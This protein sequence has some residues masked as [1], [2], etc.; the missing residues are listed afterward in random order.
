MPG[1][2]VAPR[3]SSRLW[4]P[5]GVLLI[6]TCAAVAIWF[7][8]SELEG[9]SRM[10]GTVLVAAVTVL[11][12]AFWLLFLARF[13]RWLRLGAIA[14]FVAA[15][16]AFGLSVREV[17]FLGDMLPTF[18]F[19]WEKDHDTLLEEERA[20]Q[21][22]TAPSATAQD[23]SETNNSSFD[24]FGAGRDGIVSNSK[25]DP[26]W[27]SH[28]PKQLWHQLV[29]GGYAGFALRD[30]WAVTIEQRRDDEAVVRYD[31]ATGRETWAHK[32]RAHF[33]EPLGGP[34]P[35]ATP[36]IVD[37]A[38]N[39]KND[40]ADKK[41]YA[42]G[43]TGILK[44]LDLDSGNEVW[45]A[46]IL[47]DNTN[48]VWGMAASPLVVANADAEHSHWVIVAPGA[49]SS[50]AKGR[51]VIIYDAKSGKEIRAFG[52]HR[53]GYSSPVIKKLAG[54][55]QLLVFDGDGLTSYDPYAGTE[56]WHHPWVTLPPQFINV[57]QPIVLDGD[58]VFLSSGYSVGCAM[59]Q[60]KKDA[61]PEVLWH[62]AFMR[63]K[64]TSPVHHDGYLYGLD[65]GILTCLDAKTGERK[66]KGG[67]YGHG[68][69]LL[70]DKHLLILSETG[71]LVL[72]E[73]TPEKHNQ[74][75]KL[76]ALTGKTWNPPALSAC[77]VFIR[78]HNE[79]AAYALPGRVTQDAE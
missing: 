49:Q 61:A 58:R 38:G 15:G 6:A 41:V 37:L 59:L 25:L 67:R 55:D 68:Q 75:A 74:M 36:I 9:A 53:G 21:A 35:R 63:C 4:F 78:N 65:D 47:K 39:P 14:V 10:A 72:V 70:A 20:K 28:P 17:H 32:Y 43:A 73:S 8:P 62:N 46:D 16:V 24:F 51:A 22:A 13:S 18:S 5:T 54:I 33:Q 12:L 23:R 60:V 76:G 29:G 69:L 3:R 11:L 2:E 40:K 19:R 26:E 48:I 66:W 71:D 1:A 79:M 45:S 56:L 57:A 34:G 27:S 52:D 42:L 64:F 77:Q 30:G 44:C 50:T 7:W 31:A